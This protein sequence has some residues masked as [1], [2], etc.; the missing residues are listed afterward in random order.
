MMTSLM[1]TSDFEIYG[2][3][4]RYIYLDLIQTK[5]CDIS[6]MAPCYK[7]ASVIDLQSRNKQRTGYT[8]Q[9]AINVIRSRL[10][11]SLTY[12]DSPFYM[13]KNMYKI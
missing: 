8:S 11:E 2:Q 13:C 1:K 7:L 4:Y 6:S 10:Y 3:C 9:Q 5:Q 12:S